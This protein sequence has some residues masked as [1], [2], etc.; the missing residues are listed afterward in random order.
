MNFRDAYH[1]VDDCSCNFSLSIIEQARSQFHTCIV[2]NI[3][4]FI[5]FML[6]SGN[7]VTLHTFTSHSLIHPLMCRCISRFLSSYRRLLY[8]A[9][10]SLPSSPPTSF[11]FILSFFD[12]KSSFRVFIDCLKI[13]FS[14]HSSQKLTLAMAAKCTFYLFF[15][16]SLFHKQASHRKRMIETHRKLT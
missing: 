2:L 5:R 1:F 15:P 4:I 13:L 14:V 8:H 16:H 9:C 12:I 6:V 11:K 10:H 7:R 3:F